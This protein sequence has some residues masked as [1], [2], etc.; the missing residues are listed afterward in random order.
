[1]STESYDLVIDFNDLAEKREFLN[2]VAR[3]TGKWRIRLNRARPGRT[4]QQLKYYFAAHMTLLHQHLTE[5]GWKGAN[6]KRG[7]KEELH[8]MMKDRFLRRPEID[9]STGEVMGYVAG[10]TGKLS[11]IE[12]ADFMENVAKWMAEQFD[13]PVPPPEAYEAHEPQARKKSA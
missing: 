1:M 6:G 3:A 13:I 11:T 2:R 12:M 7:T 8:E 4:Y 5:R 9:P 10:S